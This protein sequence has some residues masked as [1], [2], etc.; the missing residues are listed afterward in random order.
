MIVRTPS[1]ARASVRVGVLAAQPAHRVGLQLLVAGVV[2]LPVRG[3]DLGEV[4]AAGQLGELAELAPDDRLRLRRRCVS[5]SV[6]AAV[7][8]RSTTLGH[9]AAVGLGAGGEVAHQLGVQAAGL[10]AGRV[11]P[12]VR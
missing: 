9:R 5:A 3:D 6:S 12:P 10:P 2:A 1:A 11:Q 4:V 7:T 8:N